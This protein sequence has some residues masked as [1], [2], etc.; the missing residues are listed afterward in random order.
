MAM[1]R[2]VVVLS[3]DQFNKIVELLTPGFELAKAYL[4]AA[5][6]PEAIEPT[7]GGGEAGDANKPDA[8]QFGGQPS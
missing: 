3:D 8:S 1:P 7:D 5:K 2:D 6:P 4:A